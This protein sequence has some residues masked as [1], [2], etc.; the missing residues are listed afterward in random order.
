MQVHF[1]WLC[2]VRP[3]RGWTKE[4]LGVVVPWLNYSSRRAESGKLQSV[5]G[6]RL[7]TGSR[8]RWLPLINSYQE[9]MEKL[10]Q[11]GRMDGRRVLVLGFCLLTLLASGTACPNRCLCYR[12]TV[13]CMFL[14]LDEIPQV[15]PETTI[16][17][18]QTNTGYIHAVPYR[19]L[20]FR[21]DLATGIDVDVL[22][23]HWLCFWSHCVKGKRVHLVMAR[24]S[25][26]L[27]Q[28][29]DS[30]ISKRALRIPPAHLLRQGVGP[31]WPAD[32]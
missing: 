26:Q 28:C 5:V 25:L 30:L 20:V 1:L 6:R 27:C 19:N 10:L 17:W 8:G 7:N 9:P 3:V 2:V 22:E 29:H 12:T 32:W 11:Q 21:A 15:S 24:T 23:W 14:Q 18:V 13:R 4:L 31:S 16:L